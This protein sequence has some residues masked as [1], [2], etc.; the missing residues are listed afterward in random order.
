MYSPEEGLQKDVRHE[1]HEQS[2]VSENGRC[3]KC[4]EGNRDTVNFGPSFPCQLM[5]HISGEIS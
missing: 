5:V 4:D 3:E 2:D 1:V